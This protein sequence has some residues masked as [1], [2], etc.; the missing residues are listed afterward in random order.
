D[1]T[2]GRPGRVFDL[3]ASIDGSVLAIAHDR[4]VTRIASVGCDFDLG[5]ELFEKDCRSSFTTTAASLVGN[6]TDASRE[7]F[8]AVTVV[9]TGDTARMIAGR[10][11]VVLAP[12]P[13]IEDVRSA[14]PLDLLDDL[15]PAMPSD[16]IT[17]LASDDTA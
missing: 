2:P 8:D 17:A 11:V 10:H 6:P 5:G 14:L 13:S 12:P 9:G 3:D 1:S 15:G 16:G 7:G 4:G